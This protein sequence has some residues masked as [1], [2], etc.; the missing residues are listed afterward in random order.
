MK[1]YSVIRTHLSPYQISGFK[2]LERNTLQNLGVNYLESEAELEENSSLILLTNTHTKFEDLS[3][4]IRNA[5]KL[6]IHPNSGYENFASS[7]E[8]NSIPVII[9]N[10][11]RAQAVA[12]YA[13]SCFV[14]YWTK[15]P[16]HQ[17]WD[18][19]RLYP[20]RLMSS[21]KALIIGQGF[22][23]I[24]LKAMLNSIGVHTTTVDPR[25]VSADR[26][27]INE[28]NETFDTVIL[29]ASLNKSSH[30]IINK[31]FLQKFKPELLINP[32]R[33][34]FV[35]ES[36]LMSHLNSTSMTAYLDVF[37]NEPLPSGSLN[38]ERLFK[39]S[40]IA[41]VHDHLDQGIIDF[42]AKVIENYLAMNLSDFQKKYETSLLANKWFQGEL[43]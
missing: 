40:H 24:K 6:I 10:E 28:L 36:D 37:E 35:D 11:V 17:D 22:I 2:D 7:S 13:L 1:S 16:T 33:G 43:W 29:A 32:A 31:A 19:S 27:S 23:G 5:T 21:T 34:G 38:H 4:K 18:K 20:R 39:T 26:K 12:E 41:G 42:E 9:G 15:R 14:D 30:K 3:E 8:I 25:V